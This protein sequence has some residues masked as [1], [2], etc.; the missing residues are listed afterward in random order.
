MNI[1]Q[2]IKTVIKAD[3]G[4]VLRHINSG[5][6]YGTTVHLGYNYYE[7]GIPLAEKVL[8]VPD[9]FEEIDIPEDYDTNR[10]VIVQSKRLKVLSRILKEVKEQINSYDLT[11]EECLDNKEFFPTFGKDFM[12]GDTLVKGFKFYYDNRLWEVLQDHK[13]RAHFEPSDNT[14]EIYKEITISN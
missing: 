5:A 2:N 10:S 12:V 13:V 4:K 14:T 3:E 7:L 8:L 6:I 9:D 1:E 11:I